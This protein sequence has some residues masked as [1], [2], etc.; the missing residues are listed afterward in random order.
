[1]TK[2]EAKTIEQRAGKAA[3]ALTDAAIN[4]QGILSRLRAE[5]LESVDGLESTIATINA[6]RDEVSAILEMADAELGKR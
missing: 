3:R 5:R 6:S 2:S 1:M 4:L